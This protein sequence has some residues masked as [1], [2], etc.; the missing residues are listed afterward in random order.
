MSA[1]KILNTLNINDLYQIHKSIIKLINEEDLSEEAGDWIKS[2][3]VEIQDVFFT[4][5]ATTDRENMMKIASLTDFG[6]EEHCVYAGPVIRE[7]AK[8][9]H[10]N[11]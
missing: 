1:N 3:N 5:E 10:T 6:L 9:L 11:D 7:A 8:L 2:L 4:K